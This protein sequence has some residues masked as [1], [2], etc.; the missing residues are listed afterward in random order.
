MATGPGQ[1]NEVVRDEALRFGVDCPRIDVDEDDVLTRYVMAAQAY[2]ADVIV[3]ITGDC[4][5]IDAGVVDDTI[6][7]LDDNDFASNVFDRTYPEGLDCEV[8][9]MD[10]LLKLDRLV[11]GPE[12]EHVCSYVYTSNRFSVVSVM[13]D[14][15]YSHLKWCV[16]TE[17]D[18]ERVAPMLANGILPYEEML[19]KY[20]RTD[21]APG[22]GSATSSYREANGDDGPEP[23]GST[24]DEFYEARV[25]RK[26][27]R[28][29]DTEGW[30]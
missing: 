23:W 15:D 2:S 19:D 21:E 24:A 14:Q 8:M 26:P 1:E 17:E 22:D 4:P 30:S 6:S 25:R 3:R 5:L 20:G 28:F 18:Y 11:K 27:E 7:A 12:R 29:I 9:Y 13:G 16:D 10:T